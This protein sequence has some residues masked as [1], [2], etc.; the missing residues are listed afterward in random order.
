VKTLL[1][2]LALASLAL[3]ARAQRVTDL[4]PGNAIG[5]TDLFLDVQG[6]TGSGTGT[7]TKVSGAQL[8]TFAL[9]FAQPLNPNLTAFAAGNP[10]T[11]GANIAMTGTYPALTFAVSGLAM[12]ANSGSYTDLSN[13][14]TL[15]TLAALNSINNSNWSGT[16]LSVANGGTGTATPSLIGGTNVTVTGTWPNQTISASGGGTGT[17]TLNGAVSGSGTG[18]ITTTFTGTLSPANGGTGIITLGSG[19]QGVLGTAIDGVGGLIAT[20]TGTRVPIGIPATSTHAPTGSVVICIGDSITAGYPLVVL[21]TS[22]PAIQLSYTGPGFCYPQWLSLQPYFSGVPIYDFGVGGTRAA[23]GPTVLS[24]ASNNGTEYINGVAVTGYGAVTAS[25]GSLYSPTGTN[26]FFHW[27]G[28]ND[29]T[30]GVTAASFITSFQSMYTIEHGYGSNVVV[31]AFTST[32]SNATSVFEANNFQTTANVPSYNAQLYAGYGT[33]WDRLADINNVFSQSADQTIALGYMNTDDLH[34]LSAGYKA[35]SDEAFRALNVSNQQVTPYGIY[36]GPGKWFYSPATGFTTIDTTT[37]RIYNGGRPSANSQQIIFDPIN[38]SVNNSSGSAVIE[39]N[40]GLMLNSSAQTTLNWFNSSLNSGGNTMGNWATLAN[41]FTFLG[42]TSAN[43]ATAGW[44]GEM[45][46]STVASTGTVS[47]TTATT[48]TVTTLSL[49]PGDW[50]V[51]GHINYTYT[52]ATVTAGVAS[53]STTGTLLTTGQE[54]YDGIQL[55]PGSGNDT[56]TLDRFRVNSTGTTTLYLLTKRSFSAGTV[57]A[58][59][60]VSARRVR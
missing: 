2:L 23:T 18:T 49:S 59:G 60:S 33:S 10:F 35:I 11:S 52:G 48:G 44:N 36:H 42:T 38:D 41:G 43:N 20:D 25:A 53:F 51:E 28:I 9:T 24:T 17:I 8:E 5:D 15:G 19:V 13:K 30:G 40:V 32:Q 27:F 31:T 58:F 57:G 47:L 22:G 34:Y 14:P 46:S 7:T 4:P 29:Q 16:A 39:F 37:G 55:A 50:D 12:V 3:P 26:Y 6:Y 21:A 56:L 45:I 54:V 1:T